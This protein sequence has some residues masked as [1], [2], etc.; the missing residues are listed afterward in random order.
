MALSKRL[1]LLE[2]IN[3][4][5]LA[6]STDSPKPEIG[7]IITDLGKRGANKKWRV[8]SKPYKTMYGMAI[9]VERE[10]GKRLGKA[11]WSRE[12]P[13]YHSDSWVHGWNVHDAPSK[14]DNTWDDDYKALKANKECKK[15]LD[16]IEASNNGWYEEE[17]AILQKAKSCTSPKDD[18][19]EPLTG[20]ELKAAEVGPHPSKKFCKE[21]LKR[22]PSEAAGGDSEEY[23][24]WG[25]A[26]YGYDQDAEREVHHMHLW[27]WIE[28]YGLL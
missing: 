13:K 14:G 27:D 18:N 21:F 24:N 28:Q 3:E 5:T 23:K 6:K 19:D 1:P 2:E 12:A 8:I 11:N 17:F 10:D 9:L 15:W 4:V 16:E 20:D 22:L 25:E 26:L 7:S